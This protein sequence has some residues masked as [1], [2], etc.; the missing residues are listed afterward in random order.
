VSAYIPV[1]L[2]NLIRE[3]DRHRCCYCLT[4]EL[5]SGSRMVFDHI[6]PRAKDGETSF[7]NVCLAC[8]ACNEYKSDT[9]E[10]LDSSTDRLA[11][12]FNP[13]RQKWQDHFEWIQGNTEIHGKTAVG[14]VTVATLQV[15]HGAIVVTRQ[16]WVAVGWHPPT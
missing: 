5:N 12:S 16:R 2:R 8:R 14:R 10:A 13:R 3:S 15:N 6:Y 11:P 9:T 1:D 4:T 7:E